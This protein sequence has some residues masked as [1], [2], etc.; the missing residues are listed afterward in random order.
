MKA[1]ELWKITTKIILQNK[2]IFMDYF[3]S[4]NKLIYSDG[5]EFVIDL[6]AL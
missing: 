1:G 2:L 3:L 4:L 6:K 5:V